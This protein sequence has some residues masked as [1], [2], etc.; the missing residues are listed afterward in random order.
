MKTQ[1]VRKYCWY[2]LFSLLTDFNN[3]LELDP[4]LCD[5]SEL[6]A[7]NSQLPSP[8]THRFS[9][10]NITRIYP[11]YPLQIKGTQ[12]IWKA[13]EWNEELESDVW[14]ERPPENSTKHDNKGQSYKSVCQVCGPLSVQPLDFTVLS[15]TAATPVTH[16]E[17][18]ETLY[19]LSYIA[20]VN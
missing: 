20:C 16:M 17:T 19:K 13:G 8:T 1:R 9:P 4:R 3:P 6:C 10:Q 14:S 2:N 7:F 15:E 11:S 5:F 12:T 18:T